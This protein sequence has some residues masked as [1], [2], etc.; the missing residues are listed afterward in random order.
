MNGMNKKR[1]VISVSGLR[2]KEKQSNERYLYEND[3]ANR[4]GYDPPE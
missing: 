1:P 2:R 4:I 3:C